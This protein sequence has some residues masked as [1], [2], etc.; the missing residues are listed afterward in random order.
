MSQ[1][2]NW[3]GT[4]YSL[5][6]TGETGWGTTVTNFLADVGTNAVTQATS[7]TL[8][9]KTVQLTPGSAGS[10]ALSFVGDTGTGIGYRTTSTLSL[11]TAG[12]EQIRI[13]QYGN[14][15]TYGTPSFSAGAISLG[16][17]Y[18]NGSAALSVG[19]T[20]SVTGTSTL[21]AVNTTGDVS[22][23]G[24]LSVTGGSVKSPTGSV[25]LPGGIKMQWGTVVTNGA[26]GVTPITYN[27]SAAP[28]TLTASGS[29]LSDYAF[30]SVTST[31]A[32]MITAMSSFTAWWLAVGPQ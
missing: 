13:D 30:S 8:T 6:T 15:T 4:A 31:G 16:N 20:L 2:V 21:G 23:T 29:L 11:Y 3:N 5:P 14:I 28:Y 9:N 25:N 1:P 7:Q 17:V 26:T 19:G 10:A 22:I 18:L 12:T 24:N 32:N 27:F